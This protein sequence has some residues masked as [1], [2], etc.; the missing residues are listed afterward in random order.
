MIYPPPFRATTNNEDEN[1]SLLPPYLCRNHSVHGSY[2]PPFSYQIGTYY[3][4]NVDH[5]FVQSAPSKETVTV[6]SL[7]EPSSVPNSSTQNNAC[8]NELGKSTNTNIILPVSV[9]KVSDNTGN[10]ENIER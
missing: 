3:P 2:P 5:T 6:N 8:N 4:T 10:N 9:T 7:S 1:S